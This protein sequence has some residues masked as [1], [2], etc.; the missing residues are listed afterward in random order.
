MHSLQ[1]E[2]EI[3]LLL[4]DVVLPTMNGKDLRDRICVTN[5]AMKTLSVGLLRLS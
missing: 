4:T 1:Y 2:G 3:D 5:P